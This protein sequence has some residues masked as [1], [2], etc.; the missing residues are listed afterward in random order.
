MTVRDEGLEEVRDALEKLR[1]TTAAEAARLSEELSELQARV[2]SARTPSPRTLMRS[3]QE[4]GSSPLPTGS[5]LVRRDVLDG[6]DA[7]DLRRC[8]QHHSA[9]QQ[10][11]GSRIDEVNRL[12]QNL[13]EDVARQLGK[14]A[15]RVEVSQTRAWMT[16]PSRGG[17]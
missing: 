17:S 1:Q 16:S 3:V 14:L 15:L 12:F 6:E 13:R 2:T 9:E 4:A 8:L 11:L 5:A 10:E 7:A